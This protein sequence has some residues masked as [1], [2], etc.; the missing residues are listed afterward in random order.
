MIQI[1]NLGPI[2]DA[3][4][5]M[6]VHSLWQFAAIA[7]AC[8]IIQRYVAKSS[9]QRYLIGIVSLCCMTIVAIGTWLYY[10]ETNDTSITSNSTIV[11]TELSAE[12][13]NLQIDI[14]WYDKVGNWLEANKE[15]IFASWLAGAL[16]LFSR[17]L[18]S[19]L[20]INVL[21]RS[22]Q[23]ID[24]DSITKSMA[25]IK[26]YFKISKM[27]AIGHSPLVHSPI[28]AG[29]INPI[30]LLPT[31]ITNSISVK[32]AEAILAHEVAHYIRKDIWVNLLQ[33]TLE[34]V[35]YYH[36]GIW[37]VSHQLRLDRENCCDDMAV[38]F[39]G[40][41]I[42]YAKAL[43]NMHQLQ[44]DQPQ[45]TLALY[46]AK[47]SNFSQR[48]K[49]ILF[50]NANN[51]NIQNKTTSLMAIIVAVVVAYSHLLANNVIVKTD[52]TNLMGLKQI[53]ISNSVDTIKQKQ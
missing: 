31:A 35:F 36:P 39:T 3:S 18:L 12:Y 16:I 48:I 19:L 1:N 20:W 21:V 34:M 26:D 29:F 28:I 7:I 45:T 2:L 14:P 23:T 47:D 24:H 22:S 46:M 49:R 10:Y 8:F 6:I 51:L 42:D 43:V 25:K 37:W 30:I 33:H 52:N 27:P 11:I 17:I 44:I 4:L 15:M 13:T 50:M 41:N 5:W 40:N 53:G 32:D 38:S 9:T